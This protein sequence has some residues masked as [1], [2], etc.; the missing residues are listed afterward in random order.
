MLIPMG[1]GLPGTRVEN[2]P[3]FVSWIKGFT[4]MGDVFALWQ[5]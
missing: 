4:S 2:I 5:W 1:L 3:R